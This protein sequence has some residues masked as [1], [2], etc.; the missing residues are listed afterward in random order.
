MTYD[1][2]VWDGPHPLSNAHASSDYQR[3]RSENPSSADPTHRLR[4]VVDE[5]LRVFPDRDMP[6]GSTSPWVDTPLIGAARGSVFYLRVDQGKA[7]LVRNLLIK[8]TRDR[9]LVVYDPQK[10][11]LVP[12]AIEVERATKFQL[13]AP[14]GLNVH[15]SA[16][17]GEQ[18]DSGRSMVTILEHPDSYFYLQWLIDASGLTLEAQSEGRIPIEHRLSIAARD[19]MLS[20]GFQAGDPNWRIQWPDPQASLDDIVKVISR[21]F[22]E[23]RGARAGQAMKAQSFPVLPPG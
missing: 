20:L 8:V 3:L 4:V 18:I 15:L 9:K 12:S 13:P 5:L 16:V 10:A 1:F 23:V 21:I 19:Q 7:D 17:L 22:Y 2:V 6:G 14:G 11:C